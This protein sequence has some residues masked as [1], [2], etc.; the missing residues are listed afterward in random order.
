MSGKKNIPYH[1]VV[2]RR[3]IIIFL[4]Q[5]GYNNVDIGTVMNLDRSTVTRII[6]NKINI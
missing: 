4:K 3:I 1:L 2:V 6:K 5:V